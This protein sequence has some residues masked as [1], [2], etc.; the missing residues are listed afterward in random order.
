[1][2]PEDRSPPGETAEEAEQ[3]SAAEMRDS[4]ETCY[5]GAARARHPRRDRLLVQDVPEGSP[6]SGKLETGDELLAI[7][8]TPVA[9]GTQLRS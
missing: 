8:G 3:Q 2:V 5:S 4:P 6:S 7:D 1:M 9:G